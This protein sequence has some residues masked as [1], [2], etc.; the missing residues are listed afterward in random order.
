MYP[1]VLDV[2]G[3]RSTS[4]SIALVAMWYWMPLCGPL[5]KVPFTS[6]SFRQ[7]AANGPSG[8][9]WHDGFSMLGRTHYQFWKPTL[10]ANST[11][12]LQHTTPS[13]W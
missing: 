10:E 6:I 12:V 11:A 8:L 5:Q 9:A 7:D 4:C 3:M 1:E 13:T 2:K